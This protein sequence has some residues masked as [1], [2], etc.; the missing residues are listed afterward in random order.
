MPTQ[1]LAERIDALLPQTQCARCGYVACQPYAQAL[2]AGDVEIN[3]CPP[4]GDATIES[5]ARLLGRPVVP[6]DPE[7][8]KDW[9]YKVALIDEAWCIG[10]TI[11]IQACPVD[12][13]VGAAKFMHSVV[14]AQCT[15]CELCITPCPTDCITMLAKPDH[16]QSEEMTDTWGASHAAQ[17]RQRYDARQ[18]RLGERQRDRSASKQR[19]ALRKLEPSVKL[20]A[21]GEA[22]RR[23]RSRRLDG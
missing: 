2:A 15:G 1:S 17:A 20:G 23:V 10:C 3:R 22:V 21:I 18:Q 9:T 19:K 14:A 12:A 4:G 5:L 6:L 8:G 7:C 13:I 11:C 16:P